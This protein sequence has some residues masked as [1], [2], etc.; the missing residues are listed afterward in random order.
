MTVGDVKKLLADYPDDL[1]IVATGADSGGY[2]AIFSD[3][4]QVRLFDGKEW[5]MA[6]NYPYLLI[7]GVE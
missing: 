1:Q 5:W 7:E 4:L 3:T 2:D 6:R